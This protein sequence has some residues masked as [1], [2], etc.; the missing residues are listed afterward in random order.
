MRNPTL[1]KG[2]KDMLKV[3]AIFAI[4]V[5]LFFGCSLFSSNVDTGN[6]ASAISADTGN[7][8]G[9]PMDDPL[10]DTAEFKAGY[11]EPHE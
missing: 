1:E 5:S 3:F 2:A 9:L 6:Q 7:Y 11:G 8:G 10:R 4:C